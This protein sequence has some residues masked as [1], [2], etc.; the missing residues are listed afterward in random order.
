MRA[1]LRNCF[2]WFITVFISLSLWFFV[3]RVHLHF[4]DPSAF[5]LILA[6]ASAVLSVLLWWDLGCQDTRGEQSSD[7]S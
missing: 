7:D 4:I 2:I 6:A 3:A 1:S 5:L